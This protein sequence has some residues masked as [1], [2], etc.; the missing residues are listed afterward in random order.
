MRLPTQGIHHRPFLFGQGEVP[1]DVDQPQPGPFG[2]VSS[3]V[4]PSEY[5]PY[6]FPCSRALGLV[7]T[8]GQDLIALGG[9]DDEGLIVPR[10]YPVVDLDIP[11]S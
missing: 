6:Q 8:V 1:A 11:V 3:H 2:T 4:A 9:G 7:P 10:L 5:W